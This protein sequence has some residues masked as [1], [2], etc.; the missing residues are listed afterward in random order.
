MIVTSKIVF[1]RSDPL[2]I[3]RYLSVVNGCGAMNK[4][5]P[6]MI[7]LHEK[8]GKK[9][10]KVSFQVRTAVLAMKI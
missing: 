10:R 9:Q 3:S 6:P 4:R 5:F 1:K 2:V 7:P 8:Q